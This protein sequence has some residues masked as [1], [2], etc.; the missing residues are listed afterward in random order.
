ML[1]GLLR[2]WGFPSKASYHST[3]VAGPGCPV[4]PV[5]NINPGESWTE[6]FAAIP[7][8]DDVIFA[9]GTAGR[10]RHAVGGSAE[11]IGKDNM[12]HVHM[13]IRRWSDPGHKRANSARRIFKPKVI[14]EAS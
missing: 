4:Q 2:T 9:Q 3:R 13:D 14:L 5:W 6:G 7:T 11:G 10:R 1:A 8:L 12:N